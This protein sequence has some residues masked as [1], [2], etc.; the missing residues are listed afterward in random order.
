MPEWLKKAVFYEIYPQS[1]KDT[2]GD[3][4]GDI[5]GIIEKLDYI[6]S[7]GCNA[8]W[9][10][11]WYDSPFKDA[12]YDVRDFKKIAPR[13][14]TN[15]DAAR[16]FEEA[17]KRDMHVLLDLVAGHT[18]E[19]HEWFKKSQQAV[20]NEYTDR[21]IWTDF[22]FE[23][24]DGIPYVAGESERSAA[25]LLNFYK[26]QPALNYGFLH[27]ERPWQQPMDAPGPKATV[28]ALEDIMR[29]W[30][31]M[32]C[33]GFRVDMASSLVK[34]D[35]ENKSGTCAIWKDIT[36]KLK[37]DYPQAAM[38]SEWSAPRQALPCGFD[39]DFYL[40][41][42]GNGYSALMR[43][44]WNDAIARASTG[45]RKTVPEGSAFAGT[46]EDAMEP[47]G[48]GDHTYFRKDTESDITRF[49]DEYVAEYEAT[50]NDGLFCLLTCNHDTPRPRWNLE[51]DELKIAYAVLFTLP[52]APYLYY[53]DEI[54][55]RY[56]KV[57]TKEGGYFRT[58]ARTPMQWE[59][60]KNLGFSQADEK[61]LYLPVDPASDAPTVQNQEQDPDS[62]LH[63]VKEILAFR[64][65]REELNSDAPFELVQAKKDSPVLVYRRG[66][67]LIAV[68]PKASAHTAPVQADGEILFKIGEINR[69]DGQLTLQPQTFVVIK[70]K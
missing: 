70:E 38:V 20:K 42:P 34:K 61:D 15:E 32:G 8:L 68:N 64:N 55:M 10:N 39:M 1:F 62:L 43:D 54:G 24:G 22:C 36:A 66:D 31:D 40:N 51:P 5:E 41:I 56:L 25:Y 12:G 21:F 4:I 2:N 30:L 17:H 23:D 3:G 45:E 14:G 50:K 33:D 58:G 48:A 60:G 47:G 16:L 53:G 13:Y 9:I 46:L 63:T 44:Y 57:P 49:T 18:S 65:S 28:A 29:F 26:C 67:L 6:K 35:D 37:R 19:E 69:Q 52:G 7:L 27:P 11:P 59:P